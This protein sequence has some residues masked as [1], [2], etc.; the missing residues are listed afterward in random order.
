[1]REVG[2]RDEPFGSCCEGLRKAMTMP[3]ES[4][5]RQEDNGIL[6]L[7]VG[8]VDTAEGP[9]WFA[10]AVLYCPFCGTQIQDEETVAGSVREGD[11]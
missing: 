11:A 7:A 2:R 8:Y 1:M 3:K 9:G 10:H 5:F 6:Y 4:M